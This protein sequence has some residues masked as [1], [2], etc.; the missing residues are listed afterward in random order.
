MIAAIVRDFVLIAAYC[1]QLYDDCFAV[2]IAD[3]LICKGW[4]EIESCLLP[5]LGNDI[6]AIV[7][8]VSRVWNFSQE[9]Q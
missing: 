9:I 8:L 6:E 4:W 5:Y 7:S 3:V 1:M 2:S